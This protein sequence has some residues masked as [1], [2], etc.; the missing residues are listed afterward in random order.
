MVGARLAA[1]DLKGQLDWSVAFLDGSFAPA[2]KGGE[3]V[4]SHQERQGNQVDARGR[5]ERAPDRVPS[6]Q[7]Q[8]RRGTARRATLDN[9]RIS[10]PCHP[11]QPPAKVW[12]T[13][14]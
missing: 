11:N 4:G 1:L 3:K 13:S 10:P 7:R 2:K 14:V 6:R 8:L 12:R 5:G 9:S